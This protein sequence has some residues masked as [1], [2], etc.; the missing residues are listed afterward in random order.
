MVMSN[1]N[2]PYKQDDL[3]YP[4]INSVILY[5]ATVGTFREVALYPGDCL[6]S[7]GLRSGMHCTF[8]WVIVGNNGTI[9]GTP[10]SRKAHA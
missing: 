6:I 9:P 1:E 4:S 10:F 7:M 2:W 5:M 3:L 8:V